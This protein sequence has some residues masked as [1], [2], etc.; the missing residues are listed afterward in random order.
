MLQTGSLQISQPREVCLL[1]SNHKCVPTLFSLPHYPK[2]LISGE[3]FCGKW[4]MK[5]I[6]LEDF[7]L[8]LLALFPCPH[9]FPWNLSQG[10]NIAAAL[11]PKCSYHTPGIVKE[12]TSP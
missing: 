3:A 6:P 7:I 9:H 11:L 2:L 1:C 8:H 10:K 5:A 12:L 4:R